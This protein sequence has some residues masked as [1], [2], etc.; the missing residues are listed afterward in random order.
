[1]HVTLSKKSVASL[2]A[3]VAALGLGL[4]GPPT[5]VAAGLAAA[6]AAGEVCLAA[7]ANARQSGG[8]DGNDPNS[9][10]LAETKAMEAEFQAGVQS[11]PKRAARRG[12]R[13]SSYKGIH[14]PRNIQIDTYVHVI[15]RADGTGGVTDKMIRDQITAMNDAFAGNRQRTPPPRP[16]G[17]S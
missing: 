9:V 3:A 10:S 17:S 12:I 11:L 1:M 6:P 13:Q 16:S 4:M 2:A 5:P 7:P 14:L 8:G 15:T